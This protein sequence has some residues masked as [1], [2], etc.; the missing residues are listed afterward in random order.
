MKLSKNNIV[1]LIILD[2]SFA[3]GSIFDLQIPFYVLILLDI[4]LHIWS[5][6]H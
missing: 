1:I 5:W 2:F 6:V 4:F 3:P